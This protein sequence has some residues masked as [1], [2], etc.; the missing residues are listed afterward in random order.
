MHWA[1]RRMHAAP[2]VPMLKADRSSTIGAGLAFASLFPEPN[3]G[4]RVLSIAGRLCFCAE[5]FEGVD[6]S[7]G[8]H[9]TTGIF[10]RKAGQIK[11]ARERAQTSFREIRF[12]QM[13]FTEAFKGNAFKKE[14]SVK[15]RNCWVGSRSNAG[16]D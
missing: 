6:N 7:V 10:A 3:G 2:V 15:L 9:S 16:M 14:V 5:D 1:T 4:N 11:Y 8:R 13:A 12:R